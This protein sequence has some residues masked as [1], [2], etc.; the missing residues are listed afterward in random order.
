VSLVIKTLIGIA[1]AYAALVAFVW[2]IQDRLIYFP[3]AGREAASTPAAR[4]V[5][6]DDFTITTADG[7][8]LNV[9]WVPASSPRGAVLL[10]HGNA[11]NISHRI[12]YALMFRTL[13]Y[14]TLLVDY[15]GYG[16]SSGKPSEEGTYRDADAAW[17]WLTHTRA[18]PED[19]IVLFGESLGG[20]VAS[21]LAARHTPR[22]LV[23]AST[24][25]STVDLASQIY[26][27][28][29]V[30]LISRYRYDTLERLGR[31]RTPV[32]VIHSPQDDIIPYSHGRRLYEAAREP[33]AFLELRGG[34]NDGFVF[35]RPE[36]VRALGGFLER[37]S[38]KP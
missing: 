38:Q 23:L 2:V 5:P 18:I 3:H 28:L 10:F 29:P 25:T 11:G 21:W 8:K 19:R 14:S 13:G 7:E 17:R 4:G 22:A 16:K 9:W 24:F 35:V 33:K 1:C 26:S 31:I 27:F 37:V 30:K 6:Y 12:E 32:L 20:G 36:W 15:R 34:H